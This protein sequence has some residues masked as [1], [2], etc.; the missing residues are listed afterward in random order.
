MVGAGGSAAAMAEGHAV[1]ELAPGEAGMK[2]GMRTFWVGLC[3]AAC[4]GG[5]SSNRQ[6]SCNALAMFT[7]G[8]RRVVQAVMRRQRQ[9]QAAL[10]GKRCSPQVRAVLSAS[11]VPNSCA[12][13]RWQ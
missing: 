8:L 13:E 9:R 1:G 3:S 7:H 2:A 12:M 6:C 11:P 5:W 4:I 10:A